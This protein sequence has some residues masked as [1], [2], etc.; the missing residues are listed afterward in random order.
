LVKFLLI[1]HIYPLIF[2]IGV[3]C[4][5]PLLMGFKLPKG[6]LLLLICAAP[7]SSQ[8]VQELKP[9]VLLTYSFRM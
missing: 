1:R 2:K 4:M 3:E 6:I 8:L 9:R 7:N 5:N